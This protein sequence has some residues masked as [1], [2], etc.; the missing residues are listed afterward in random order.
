MIATVAHLM[1][2]GFKIVY[3]YTQSDEISL[4]LHRDDQTFG[5]KLRKLNSV[6]AGE[7][8]AKF[9]TLL[10][11]VAAFDCRISQLTSIDLVVDYF[12]WRHEDSHRNALNA[13][14]YWTL[15][16]LGEPAKSVTEKLSGMSIG[17]KNELLYRVGKINFNDLPDW[18]KRGTGFYWEAYQKES[19][20]LK[21]GETVYANRRR[22]K[23]DMQ[24]L[25]KDEYSSFVR[26]IVQKE[27]QDL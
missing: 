6:F 20:N 18:Q 21:T 9:S 22:L 10:G 19:V 14:C 23:V 11:S 16:K 1:N 15:R 13:H 7:A 17:D 27:H 26:S 12:R 4:L 8:S 24:L 5:R 25:M 3:G 2:C